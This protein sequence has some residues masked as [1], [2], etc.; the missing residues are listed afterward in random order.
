MR[1]EGGFITDC[2]FDPAQDQH[3]ITF[4]RNENAT[5]P[6]AFYKAAFALDDWTGNTDHVL[7]FYSGTTTHDI[8]DAELSRPKPKL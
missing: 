1:I 4:R 2:V 7:F 5:D 3:L 8:D 6:G